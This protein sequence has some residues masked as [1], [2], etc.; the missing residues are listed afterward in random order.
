[1]GI[2]DGYHGGDHMK[3]TRVSELTGGDSF[4]PRHEVVK[5][6]GVRPETLDA[7]EEKG[8]MPRS[9]MIGERRRFYAASSIGPWLKQRLREVGSAAVDAA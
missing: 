7:W 9:V 3:K 2:W 4:V 1:M 5:V 6:L 8:F